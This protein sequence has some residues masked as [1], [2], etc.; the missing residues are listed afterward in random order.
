METGRKKQNNKTKP[1][2]QNQTNN[3]EKTRTLMIK[4]KDVREMGK[5]KEGVPN[6]TRKWKPE[7]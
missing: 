1:H 2:T 7:K 3:E 4:Y 5:R 6:C